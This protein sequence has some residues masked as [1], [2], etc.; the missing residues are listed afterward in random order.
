M[1]ENWFEVGAKLVGSFY[2]IWRWNNLLI[3]SEFISV[4]RKHFKEPISQDDLCKLIF[5]S[6]ITTAKLGKNAT[7]FSN[8]DKSDISK[9]LNQKKNIPAEIQSHAFDK[10]ISAD[11][12]EYF[13]TNIVAELIPEHF[14]DLYHQML[15]FIDEDKNISDAHK[16]KLHSMAD[17]ENIAEFLI[18]I[19]KYVIRQE[20][21]S[22]DSLSS[23][24]NLKVLGISE[25]NE[26]SAKYPLSFFR[27]RFECTLPEVE[28]KIKNLLKEINEFTKVQSPEDFY[29]QPVPTKALEFLYG[30]INFQTVKISE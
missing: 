5:D 10:K 7:E 3:F 18:D 29:S 13:Q 22:P 21:K 12:K 27:P 15:R 9:I 8:I 24:A 14:D 28:I 16:K 26:L 20:N 25:D 4:L 11:M 17:S 23:K 30:K 1:V 19:F 6:V 2:F